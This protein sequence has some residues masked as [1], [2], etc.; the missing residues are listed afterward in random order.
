MTFLQ[1]LI[2][3]VKNRD[4]TLLLARSA[5]STLD[6]EDEGFRGL[7]EIEMMKICLDARK[8]LGYQNLTAIIDDLK[9]SQRNLIASQATKDN[10]DFGRGV[11]VGINTV[12]ERLR[13]LSERSRTKG[14]GEFNKF[15]AI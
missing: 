7:T 1:R 8:L 11:L 4:D 9:V 13:V 10:L 6:P 14:E 15:D 12:A 2:W 5:L 3:L